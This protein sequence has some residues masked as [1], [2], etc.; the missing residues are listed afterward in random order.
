MRDNE[1]TTDKFYL[2]VFI[3]IVIVNTTASSNTLHNMPLHKT[4]AQVVSLG[5]T[6]A[7][8]RLSCSPRKR[9]N[10]FARI[11]LSSITGSAG[12]VSSH[13]HSS[14]AVEHKE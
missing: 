2:S 9:T 1:I 7:I 10:D 8:V 13:P 6:A 11:A 12:T 4:K 14:H 3:F 5:I